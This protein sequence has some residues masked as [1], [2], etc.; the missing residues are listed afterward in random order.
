MALKHKDGETIESYSNRFRKLLRRATTGAALDNR[1]QV[2]YYINGLSPAYVSQVIIA[3]PANLN[4]AITRAKLVESGAKITLQNAGILP[5]AGEIPIKSAAPLPEKAIDELTKQMQQLSINYANLYAAFNGQ[6]KPRRNNPRVAFNSN[7]QTQTYTDG[8][9]RRCY[10]CGKL[11]HI[12]RN[13]PTRNNNRRNNN[14]RNERNVQ[15]CDNDYEADG[16]YSDEYEEYGDDNDCEVETYIS[17]RETRS[18]TRGKP[19]SEGITSKNKRSESRKEE[20][21]RSIVQDV[22]ETYEE[23]ISTPTP[24]TVDKQRKPRRKMLPA[25]IEKLDEF[26]VA[27]Y[28]KDL[29]CGLSVGQ[30]A[31]AIPKYRS[32]LVR[33]MRRTREREAN[34]VDHSESED[35]NDQFTAAKCEIYIGKE[36]VTAVVDSGAATSIITDTLL[37][38]LKQR[39]NQPSKMV[40]VTA[41]GSRVRATGLV[42]ELPISLQGML[43]KSPVHVIPSK[44]NV[45]ILG[46]DWLRRIDAIIHYKRETLIINHKGRTIHVPISYTIKRNCITTEI[47]EDS[48]DEYESEDDLIESQIYYS[49]NAYSSDEENLEYNPWLNHAVEPEFQ[50]EDELM[51][52]PAVFLAEAE[53]LQEEEKPK[54]LHLGPLL[55]EQQVSFNNLLRNYKDICA[56]SQTQIGRTDVIKHKIITGDAIPIAQPAYRSNPKNLTFIKDEVARMEKQGL[57]RKSASPWASPVVVVGKKGGD[58]RFC[59]DYRKL[60][61]VMKPDMYPLP[62]IDDMLESFNGAAWFTTLDLASG[63]WQVEMDEQDVEKTAFKTPFGLYEFLVMPFGLAYAPGTFQRLM[64]YIL[65]DYLGKFVAVYLDDIIIYSKGSLENHLSHI[66]Q[67]FETLR[68]AHLKIKL[69][70]CHFCFPNIHF[71][72]HVVGRDGIK[73]DP[74]KIQKI[75]DF[76]EPKS[77]TQL[78]SALGLFSYYRRFIKDF[79]NI[80]RPLNSLLK[81]DEPYHWEIKQQNAFDALKQKLISA[82]I[83]IYPDFEKS[84]V[85]YTDASGTGIGAVL[86]QIGNDKKEHVVAYASRSMNKAEQNYPITD[87]ECLAIVWAIKYFQHYLELRPFILVTDHSALKWLQTSKIPKG[88]RARWVM[89]LQQFKFE[90]KHRPGKANANADALS[91]MYGENQAECYMLTTDPWWDAPEEIEISI[92]SKDKGKQPIEGIHYQPPPSEGSIYRQNQPSEERIEKQYY[93]WDDTP[94]IRWASGRFCCAN[95][96]CT[97]KHISTETEIYFDYISNESE[98]IGEHYEEGHPLH[99][100]AYIHFR[101]TV[102][103]L[104]S[105]YEANIV[106]K[107]VVAGQPIKKGGS[108]CDNFCDTWNYHTHTYCRLCKRNLLYGTS[109]HECIMGYNP[110]QI[111]PEMN[112]AFLINAPWWNEPPEIVAENNERYLKQFINLYFAQLIM[113]DEQ[114]NADDDQI[115]I[116]DVI[117]S[118]YNQQLAQS[119]E[120]D[121]APLD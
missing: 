102:R 38:H 44:D 73:P 2:D 18:K 14:W 114:S 78:R 65:H 21:L 70:K 6:N 30:A 23:E 7:N 49:D 24:M 68:R 36:P 72:G 11:G 116:S 26:S 46:N 90:I 45:L 109:A 10:N 108:K 95:F 62:R 88:R 103:E 59:V 34:Y 28:L 47:D 85:L 64:N 101:P 57:I 35:E 50:D 9:D 66:A 97:C 121:V 100:P 19:Y 69:K 75:K 76:P 53:K 80:A 118:Y 32:G 120:V 96:V 29:P 54:E 42:D 106:I 107:N 33:A 113:E 39:I 27:D 115:S 22:P 17:T 40:I 111:H 13:C 119:L 104:I 79:S 5:A 37:N 93:Y 25:P 99:I 92:S 8:S 61:A 43:I 1:Y 89:D 117:F 16:Y 41:N 77:L 31:H 15:L 81:K 48:E 12:S 84:F 63:Y 91:R 51:E 55:Y 52:N 110:G 105:F 71:L 83:L 82:P 60:N 86:S 87:Q 56:Q 58:L 98:S 74:E 94:E 112:P 3:A 4:E 20:N 67:V